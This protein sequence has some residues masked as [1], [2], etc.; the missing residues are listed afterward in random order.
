MARSFPRFN[1]PI[2]RFYFLF[3]VMMM[4]EKR[5]RYNRARK[6]VLLIGRFVPRDRLN[7]FI[8]FNNC[9]FIHIHVSFF[10]MNMG[11]IICFVYI[12]AL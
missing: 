2:F 4:W 8:Y 12:Y 6:S 7:I 1:I 5:A 9:K 10:N 11:K 3:F